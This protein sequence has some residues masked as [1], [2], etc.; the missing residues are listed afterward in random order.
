V[1]SGTESL[2]LSVA[3]GV[4]LVEAVRQRRTSI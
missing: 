4:A 3:A 2:N 1:G